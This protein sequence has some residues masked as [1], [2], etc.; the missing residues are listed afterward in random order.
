MNISEAF[1]SNFLKA[2]DLQGRPVVVTIDSAEVEEIG[3]GRDKEKKLVIG[4]HGKEKKLIC[5][6][7]NASTIAKLYGDDTDAWLG[8]KITLTSRE[9]EFGGEM[10]LAIRVSLQK[11]GL[12]AP[13][14]KPAPKP[15]TKAPEPEPQPEA[16]PEGWGEE[17]DP[18]V[19]F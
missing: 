13:A 11:P 4:F 16:P 8:Q 3:Q 15:V 5:N 14:A 12:A 1:P 2:S 6:K 18:S 7:T 10:V 17:G 9:V 19:P